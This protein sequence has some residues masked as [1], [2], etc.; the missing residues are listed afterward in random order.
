MYGPTSQL[1]AEANQ[2][3]IYRYDLNLTFLVYKDFTNNK[4]INCT[5]MKVP[6]PPTAKKFT[7]GFLLDCYRSKPNGTAPCSPESSRLGT[8][9]VWLDDLEGECPIGKLPVSQ[10]H[11]WMTFNHS[12]KYDRAAIG[13]HTNTIE[14]PAACKMDKSMFAYADFT[15]GWTADP[16]ESVFEPPSECTEVTSDQG[17]DIHPSLL[18]AEA[19]SQVH[20]AGGAWLA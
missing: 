12:G 3:V 17:L 16:A 7:E 19:Q 2:V 6:N 20:D 9:D 4:V 8:C 11:K 1:P 15:D 18:L 10:Y 13:S 14:I 5:K